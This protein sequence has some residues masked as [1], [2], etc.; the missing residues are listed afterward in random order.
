MESTRDND[1]RMNKFEDNLQ[2]ILQDLAVIKTSVTEGRA[3]DSY[4]IQVLTDRVEKLE[5]NQGRVV[6]LLVAAIIAA[7]LSLVIR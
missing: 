3:A 7:L 1:T 4:K 2:K 6:W 5:D